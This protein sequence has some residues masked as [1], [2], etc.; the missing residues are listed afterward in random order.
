MMAH[1]T[2]LMVS[3]RQP[4]ANE[5]ELV[6]TQPNGVTAVYPL[7]VDQMKL[8]ASQAVRALCGWRGAP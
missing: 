1:P 2:R 7:S 8:L 3:L 4:T 6:V 5:V